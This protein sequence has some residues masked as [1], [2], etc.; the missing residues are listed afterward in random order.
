M[1]VD[2]TYEDHALRV[3]VRDDGR[4]GT[5]IPHAARGGGFGLVGL[6]ERVTALG[7]DL[8]TGPAPAGAGRSRRCCRPWRDAAA[9]H[10]ATVA[11]LVRPGVRGS[12]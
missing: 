10:T 2:L 7:G 6:T 12:R 3:T 8:R 4:G 11:D 9:A 5:R 1:A